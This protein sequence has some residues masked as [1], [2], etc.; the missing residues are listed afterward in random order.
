MKTTEWNFV[1]RKRF[2]ELVKYNPYEWQR[3]T[4]KK[5]YLY[6]KYALY[7]SASQGGLWVEEP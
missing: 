2:A 1:D 3:T 5:T 6:K 7:W 4:G